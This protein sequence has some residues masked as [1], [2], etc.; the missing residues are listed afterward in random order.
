MTGQEN[1]QPSRA[2]CQRACAQHPTCEFWTWG[3]GE[4]RG[5]CY[6]KTAR[7]NVTPGLDSY[8]SGSKHCKLPEAEG[9][10]YD[11]GQPGAWLTDRVLAAAA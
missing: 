3:K 10:Y 5:P 1:F 11:S 6:L 9:N 8:V 7:D 4:P 2:A